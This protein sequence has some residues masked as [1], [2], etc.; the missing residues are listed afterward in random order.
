MSTY[1]AIGLMSGTSLDGLDLCYSKFTN[2]SSDWDFEILECETL[3]Y[4]SV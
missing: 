3:P 4:S 2:N 1:Y